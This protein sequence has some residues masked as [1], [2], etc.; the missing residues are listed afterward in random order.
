MKKN[1]QSV[2]IIGGSDGPASIF[3]VGNKQK[4]KN[5]IIRL[6]NTLR[7]KRHQHR[8]EKA[9]RSIKLGAHTLDETISYMKEH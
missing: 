1:A 9:K 2:S 5:L 6:E 3:L 7:K 8:L 4:E